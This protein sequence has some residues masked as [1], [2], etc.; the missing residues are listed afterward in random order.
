MFGQCPAKIGSWTPPRYLW[1]DAGGSL[2]GKRQDF[3]LPLP[4]LA[5]A[6]LRI[7][8]ERVE[9][10]SARGPSLLARSPRP[11]G[12]PAT[13]AHMTPPPPLV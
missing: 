11:P 9:S 10:M 1:T 13:A 6:P 4:P 12:R 7:E 2:A 3:Y 5:A 8:R